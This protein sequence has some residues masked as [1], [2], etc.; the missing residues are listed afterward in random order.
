MQ[1]PTRPARAS[2]WR[3]RPPTSCRYCMAPEPGRRQEAEAARRKAQP[4]AAT[5]GRRLA[6]RVRSA[7][8]ARSPTAQHGLVDADGRTRPRARAPARSPGACAQAG[9]WRGR[10]PARPCAARHRRPMRARCRRPYGAAWPRR[11]R[12]RPGPAPTRF[13]PAR[14][15]RRPRR[16]ARTRSRNAVMIGRRGGTPQVRPTAPRRR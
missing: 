4:A 10:R 7:G 1:P 5:P 14:A 12:D 2:V 8:R 13:R 9:R 3:L 6:S 11:L 16:H 15:S